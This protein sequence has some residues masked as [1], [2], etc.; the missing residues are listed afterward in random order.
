MLSEV[1]LGSRWPKR[2][3]LLSLPTSA[4]AVS[5][6]CKIHVLCFSV[7]GHYR[8]GEL[9]VTVPWLDTCSSPAKYS[10]RTQTSFLPGPLQVSLLH[11][12]SLWSFLLRLGPRGH[13]NHPSRQ[14]GW[15]Q[16]CMVRALGWGAQKCGAPF[17]LRCPGA[18]PPPSLCLALHCLL[19]RRKVSNGQTLAG[20]A[21][22]TTPPLH[23]ASWRSQHPRTS[24]RPSR[25]RDM[26]E[27]NEK[28]CIRSVS[29]LCS[30]VFSWMSLV[31][32][33]LGKIIC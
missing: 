28:Q 1:C 3:W 24:A 14:G 25:Q 18:G 17:P 32:G 20:R 2:P 27:T 5:L 9:C 22:I 8:R 19:L 26:Q 11:Y 6:K 23:L 15:V 16:P 4:S 13:Q 7:I 30:R 12:T 21:P 29:I 31:T 10:R 33:L